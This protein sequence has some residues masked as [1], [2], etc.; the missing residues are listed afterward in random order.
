MIKDNQAYA[1]KKNTLIIISLVL[2]GCGIIA[3]DIFAI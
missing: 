2:I 3:F 1:Y